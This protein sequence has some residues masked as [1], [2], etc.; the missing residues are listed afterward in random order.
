MH[1]SRLRL[2][3]RSQQVRRD[4]ASPYDMHRTLTRCFSEGDASAPSRFLWRIEPAMNWTEAVV[5][6][7]SEAA[8][9]WDCIG[10]LRGYL[11]ARPESRR[12]ALDSLLQTSARY[13]FRLFA[14]PTV[15]REGRRYGLVS[16]GAQLDWLGRQAG[17]HGF[18][19]EEALVTASDMV[20][21]R[22]GDMLISLQRACFEGCLRVVDTDA[23][24]RAV[25]LGVGPGKAF[26][27]GLLSLARL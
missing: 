16:E 21:A 12:L 22:K 2:D 15:T 13:R 19:V 6:L 3:P 5:L 4:L 1:L 25:R 10:S 8:G 27:F 24:E 20:N 7:Q 26:G 9:N 14:N 23:L 11:K 18:T 17:K